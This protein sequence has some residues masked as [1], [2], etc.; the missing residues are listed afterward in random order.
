MNQIIKL[1]RTEVSAD[2]IR[3]TERAEKYMSR[4]MR[5]TGAVRNQ[6]TFYP[7]EVK[8]HAEKIIDY[9]LCGLYPIPSE[10]I[11]LKPAK[12]EYLPSVDFVF[13]LFQEI[14]YDICEKCGFDVKETES[15]KP[16][17]YANAYTAINSNTVMAEYWKVL[18]N[19]SMIELYLV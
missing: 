17:F 11:D 2:L 3:F 16:N 12:F 10:F 1:N 15:L 4:I 8:I 9:A 14:W 6:L 13:E 7:K 19:C 5:L 18:Q